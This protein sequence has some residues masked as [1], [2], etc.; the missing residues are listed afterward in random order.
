MISGLLLD[1]HGGAP[2]AVVV[3]PLGVF[4]AQ[5]DTA[6]GGLAAEAADGAAGA[7]VGVVG[8]GVEQYAADDAGRPLGVAVEVLEVVPL[9]ARAAAGL[10][11]AGGG[12]GPV[13]A[14]GALEFL[15][16]LGEQFRQRVVDDLPL[17]F[18]QQAVGQFLHQLG[19]DLQA[20]DNKTQTSVSY[21]ADL[22][23][24]NLF[25]LGTLPSCQDLAD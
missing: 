11:G 2:R 12:R 21:S 24:K 1:D 8:H 14:G 19:E 13:L 5:A 18:P 16:Q 17:L 9:A 3:D 15:H 7:L 22:L 6:V 23:K 10:V 25:H 4:H 20:L